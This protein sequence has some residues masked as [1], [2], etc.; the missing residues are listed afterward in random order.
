MDRKSILPNE[1]STYAKLF[2]V[3]M[4]LSGFGDGII[5][6]VG[7]LYLI[8]LGFESAALGTM[9][10]LKPVGTALVT[11][12][13]GIIAD[14]YSKAKVL[15]SGFS[16]FSFA[17]ILLLTSTTIEMFGLAM[18]L[19]GL[20]DA[21]FVVLGPLYSSFFGREDMDRAFG[22]HGFLNIVAVSMGSLTGFIPPMLVSNFGFSLQSSYWTLMLFATVFFF[23]RMPFY[24]MSTRGTLELKSREAF[25]FTLRSK[26]V[27]AKFA[28]L[29]MLAQ[30]GYGVFFNLFPFYVHKKFGAQSDALG[31]LFFISWFV[32]AGANITASKVSERLGTHKTIV[33]ASLL[34][35]PFYFAISLAPNLQWL[36]ALFIVRLGL[37]NISSPLVASLFMRLLHSEEKATANGIRMMMAMGGD[38][39]ATWLGGRFME[40]ISLDFSVCLGAGLYVSYA[41]SFYF[42]LRNEE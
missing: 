7:Q 2:L 30:M 17:M 36:S 35:A 26:K 34:C 23:A 41:L 24:L 20:S 18:L 12:L 22:L 21:T 4:V 42:L 14:R 29:T 40:Q 16:L 19:I 10:M 11:I 9:L 27:V 28:M 8:S 6:V 13:A 1:V 31:V 38:T 5:L 39:V 33:T 32:S 15:F 3:G 37:A 25:R